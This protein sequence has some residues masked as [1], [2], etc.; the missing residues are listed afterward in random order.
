MEEE[1]TFFPDHQGQKSLWN[2]P[3]ILKALATGYRKIPE[4]LVAGYAGPGTQD[5]PEV[6]LAVA[7]TR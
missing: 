6:A 5:H 1:I 4:G 2:D 3:G 7:R